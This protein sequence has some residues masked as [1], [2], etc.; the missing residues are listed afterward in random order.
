MIN[1]KE[2]EDFLT[3]YALGKTFPEEMKPEVEQLENEL[4]ENNALRRELDEIRKMANRLTDALAEEPL[5]SPQEEITYEDKTATKQRRRFFN[6]FILGTL[7]ACMVVTITLSFLLPP[8]SNFRK[9]AVIFNCAPLMERN[10]VMDYQYPANDSRQEYASATDE[11]AEFA[12][13]LEM[14]RQKSVAKKKENVKSTLGMNVTADAKMEEMA[15]MSEMVADEEDVLYMMEEETEEADM[16]ADAEIVEEPKIVE[17]QPMAATPMTNEKQAAALN[18]RQ[19]SV[20][21][22]GNDWIDMDMH[23]KRTRAMAVERPQPA[24][25]PIPA[26]VVVNENSYEKLPETGFKKPTDAPF[27]TFGVDVDTA[28]YTQMRNSLMLECGRLP[29]PNSVR[30]EE[31]VNYFRYNL[32]KPEEGSE[33]PFQTTVEIQKH[34]WQNG[35]YMAMVA[36]QGREIPAEKR[37]KL[38]LVFLLDVSGSMSDWNKLPLVKDGMMKLLDQL[39]PQDRVA[40]VTYADTATTVLEPTAGNE[41]AKI[42]KSVLQLEANGG[43]AGSDGLRRAYDLARE[44]FDKEAVN[45]I[46]LCSDGDFNVGMTNNDDL[47]KMIENE[48]KS[49]IFL[50]VL[51]FGMGN[52]K[53]D[54]LQRL[55][56]HGNGVYGYVDTRAEAKK[57]L[58][59]DVVGSMITI[60]KDVKLQIEFNPTHVAAYRLIGYESRH[61]KDRDFHDDKKDA[62]DIGAGHRVIALYEIVPT[63]GEIPNPE[64]VDKPRYQ[65]EN[66]DENAD[67]N[68]EKETATEAKTKPVND[69]PEWLFVKLRWKEPTASES[70]LKTFPVVFTPT[71]VEGKAPSDNFQFATGV[72]LYAQLLRES[73][74]TGG[75]SFATVLELISPVIGEDEYRAEFK[76]L[77][78]MVKE[79]R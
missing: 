49:G 25:A 52:Y 48:A 24:P 20:E 54:R 43:T 46:I 36:I 23:Y 29:S 8:E 53:D 21:Q 1:W 4:R 58:C 14:N 77:V 75:A 28:S 69:S 61:L 33:C 71:D 65:S 35:L 68:A 44:N 15:E 31:Y 79:Q 60:A 63:G 50:N 22:F 38:N 9:S 26:P 16:E 57:M 41:K 51:G 45:R 42:E 70:T 72:A 18:S 5:P 3:A 62:G 76:R 17:F 47:Q 55:A 40:V 67:E 56:E 13:A 7:M 73:D 6:P 34:P 10:A 39:T 2:K 74:Y 19:S 30:V 27:S 78:E 37:P 12:P 64:K 11:P 32:P 59:D 66:T